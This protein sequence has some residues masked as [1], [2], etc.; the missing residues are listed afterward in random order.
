MSKQLYERAFGSVAYDGL[1]AGATHPIDHKSVVLKAG[2]G[3][4]KRGS[5]LAVA[6]DDLAVLVDSSKTDGSQN[7]DSIL[8]ADIDTGG[9]DATENIV[10][11]AYKSGGPF[12]RQALIFGG[13]D[14]ADKHEGRLRELGIYL[15]DTIP[16]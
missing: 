13:V 2:Q 1:I 6:D 9:E 8:I 3:V 12:K 5:V 16:Y 15:T 4:L 7:A 11:V 10:A 14:T